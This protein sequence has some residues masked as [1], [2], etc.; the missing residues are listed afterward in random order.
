MSLP[1]PQM[2]TPPQWF[3][4]HMES[5]LC[6]WFFKTFLLNLT[7]NYTNLKTKLPQYN[8]QGPINKSDCLIPSQPIYHF[9]L[10]KPTF[11]YMRYGHYWISVSGGFK[12]RQCQ[13]LLTGPLNIL[14]AGPPTNYFGPLQK[15]FKKLGKEIGR[16]SQWH[17]SGGR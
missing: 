6:I 14:F 5:D 2:R 3:I 7:I 15:N 13:Q 9:N 11:L 1:K 16:R 10:I 17:N 8:M 12:S 4:F